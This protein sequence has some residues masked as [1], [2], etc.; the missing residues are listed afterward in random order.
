MK[1]VPL[2]PI[3]F[4]DFHVVL[5]TWLWKQTRYLADFPG[6][7]F[8]QLSKQN[9]ICPVISFEFAL[10]VANISFALALL[11]VQSTIYFSM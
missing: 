2:A 1:N 3:Q 7:T 4:L 11:N 10:K 6:T 5:R 8:S 9:A